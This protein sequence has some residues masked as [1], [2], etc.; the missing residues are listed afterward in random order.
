MAIDPQKMTYLVAT[1][2]AW[3][4][5]HLSGRVR[6]MASV[7]WQTNSI[8]G[9]TP[10]PT[11]RGSPMAARTSVHTVGG[12]SPLTIGEEGLIWHAENTASGN[13]AILECSTNSYCC[14]TNR[15]D[16]GCCDT[17]SSRFSLDSRKAAISGGGSSPSASS[18]SASSFSPSK[19]SPTASSETTTAKPE[20]LSSSQAT[21]AT[22]SQIV[23]SFTS[24]GSDGVQTVVV[25]SKVTPGPAYA[26]SQPQVSPSGGSTNT[27]AIVGGAVGGAVALIALAAL[28]F[29]LIRRRRHRSRSQLS[30]PSGQGASPMYKSEIFPDSP[31]PSNTSELQGSS[32]ALPSRFENADQVGAMASKRSSRSSR[33]KYM[34]GLSRFSSGSQ[35]VPPTP[36]VPELYEM[37][38]DQPV[39]TPKPG[40]LSEL[41]E[42]PH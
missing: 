6:T 5:A 10:A 25:T 36:T 15:P 38:G 20:T 32:P 39:Q 31:Y 24:Q 1:E 34:S 17:T 37:P 14:D 29:F 22:T 7:I 21:E 4:A 27:G 19:T 35:K 3:L 42:K 13:E 26:T 11:N 40:R 16:T 23:S 12:I 9:A 30:G 28:L 2:M 41:S 33:L 18:S 8:T